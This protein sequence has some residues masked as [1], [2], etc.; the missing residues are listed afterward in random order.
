[1]CGHCSEPAPSAPIT[2]TMFDFTQHFH[3]ECWGE[4]LQSQ[5]LAGD[6]RSRA[7][8]GDG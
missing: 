6:E 5:V 2:L 1:M 8:A 3:T 7:L 4:F